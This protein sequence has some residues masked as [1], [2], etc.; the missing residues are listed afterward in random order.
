MKKTNFGVFGEERKY[1]MTQGYRS[2][3]LNVYLGHIKENLKYLME[4]FPFPTY[5]CAVKADSYGLWGAEVLSAMTEAGCAYFC[6][7]SVE[8][9]LEIRKFFPDKAI[10][11][12]TPQPVESYPLLLEKKIEV[13][14]CTVEEARIIPRG[15]KVHIRVQGGTEFFPCPKTQDEFDEIYKTVVE[16][17]G[18]VQGA[19]CHFF[20]SGKKERT[21]QEL[22]N[23]EKIIGNQ[24]ENIPLIH[25]GGSAM[26]I[27]YKKP[28]FVTGYRV[29]N[30]M[31]GLENP[32][33]PL[34][35]TYVLRSKISYLKKVKKGEGVG[36]SDA[37]V[38]EQDRTI[39]VVPIGFGDGFVRRNKGSFVY[40]KDKAYPIV[41]VAMDYIALEVDENILA[42][43][44]VLL[45]R[46][47]DHAEKIAEHIGGVAEESLATLAKRI[48]RIYE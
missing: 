38:A 44:E 42:G 11:I 37:F 5:M 17:G 6:V 18:V 30:A 20:N 16:R 24:S 8:E 7:V 40:I 2:T 34:K 1:M 35:T 27:D 45:I 23:F 13:T 12:M 41:F 3:T 31:L 48:Q 14:I 36:Y 26:G 19:F 25:I 46:D 28:H 15:L 22:E 4:H 21:Q 47:A 43:D 29:G 9:A 39:G 10:L 33:L 32:E